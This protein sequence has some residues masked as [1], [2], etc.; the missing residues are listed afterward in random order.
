MG[1]AKHLLHREIMRDNAAQHRHVPDVMARTQIIEFPREPALG[2]AGG[3]NHGADEVDEHAGDGRHVEA[4]RVVE[5][6]EG[7]ELEEG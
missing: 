7:D 1:L 5:P 3:I 4:R 2:H 6:V